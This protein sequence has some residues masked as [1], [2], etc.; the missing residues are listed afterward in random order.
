MMSR[1]YRPSSGS[2]GLDFEA[3]FCWVCQREA[4]FR[5][6]Q[7]G[8]D[9]CPIVRAAFMFEVTDK[10]YPTQWIEDESGPR[11]IEFESKIAA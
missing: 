4:T 3:Q 7:D 1:K 2:E 11:C 8:T 9:A 5:E 6:T 10:E